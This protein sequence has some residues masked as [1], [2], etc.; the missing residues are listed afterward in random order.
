[1]KYVIIAL[2]AVVSITA[3][4]QQTKTHNVFYASNVADINNQQT[5]EL[6]KLISPNDSVIKVEINAYADSEGK[7]EANRELSLK[8]ANAI[9][10]FYESKGIHPQNIIIKAHGEQFC[11]E[12][13]DLKDCRVA[14]IKLTTIP[15]PPKMTVEQLLQR[16]RPEPTA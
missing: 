6:E 8:R 12:S 10:R 1:M 9:A 15:K 2:L 13:D 4:G 3:Q 14:Q 16:L 11:K 5:K 7:I